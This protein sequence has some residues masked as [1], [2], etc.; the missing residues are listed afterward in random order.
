MTIT[1]GQK[2]LGMGISIT[3]W[4]INQLKRIVVRT[5]NALDLDCQIEIFC[6]RHEAGSQELLL[7]C[8]HAY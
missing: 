2:V 1:S 5:K 7:L 8:S 3:I 6:W 4:E